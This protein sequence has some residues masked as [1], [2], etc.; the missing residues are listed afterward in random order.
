MDKKALM[1][2]VFLFFLKSLSSQKDLPFALVE[3]KGQWPEHV[4]FASDVQGG[5]V[6]FEK[7][8]LT[9]HLFDLSSII[10][11]HNE[12]KEFDQDDVRIKGH[13]YH[14]D[15]LG[16]NN[17][18]STIAEQRQQAYYNYFLGNDESG[19]AGGCNAFAS[20]NR[21]NFYNGIDLHFYTNGHVLKYDFIASP[22]ADVRQIKLKYRYADK[23]ELENGRLKITTSV[24]E[25][26]EQRPLAWQIIRGVKKMVECNYRL[27][28]DELSFS[29][30]K[31]YDLGY[32]LIIDPELVFSTYSGSFANN[33]GYTATYDL[34]GNLYGGGSVF[35]QGYPVT[36]G[37][38]QVTFNG[39]H[40]MLGGIDMGLTKYNTSGTALVWSTYLGGNGDDLP[41]SLVVNNQGEL[42]V[43]GTTGSNT[44]PVTSG[45]IDVSFN[46]GTTASSSGTG[47]NFLN[48]SDIVVT[49]FNQACT[50]LIASTYIGGTANDGL[51]LANALRYNY[52]DEFR[53]EIT[54]DAQGNP[55]IVS[56]TLSSDFPVFNAFQSSL[57]GQQD[58]VV[59]KLLPDMS[60]FVWSSYLGGSGNDSGF[61]A[62]E[63]SSGEVYICGGTNSTDFLQQSNVLQTSYGGGVADG[64]I[65]RLNSNGQSIASCTYWGSDTY[66]QVYFIEIDGNGM[67]YVFGQTRATDSQMIINASYNTPGSGNLL[68]K[69]S[70]DLSQV[71]WS[72]VFGPNT[73]R[74]TLSPSA[75]LVDYCNRVYISGWGITQVAGNALNPNQNLSS[76]ATM[77]V[78]PDAYDGTCNSGDFYMAVF[79]ENMNALEYATFFGGNQSSEHVDGG[80][81]RF[82]RKGVIYQSACAGCGGFDDFPAY[83]S[84]VWSAQNNNNCNNGVYKFDFQLPLTIADFEYTPVGCTNRPVHFQSTATYAEFYQWDFG[85]GQTSTATHPLHQYADVG[86][87]T[88]RLV[89]AS[90]TT[91]NGVDTLYKTIQIEQPVIDTLNDLHACYEEELQ[92]GVPSSNPNYQYS[93]SPT[94]YLNNPNIPNPTFEAGATTTYTVSVDRGGCVD[95]Y[96]Q[97]VEVTQ[98]SLQIPGDTTLCDDEE[99]VLA[100]MMQPSAA[101]I[102]W[103]DES[104][105]GN[106]LNDNST[107][108]D[109]VVT[110]SVPTTYYVQITMNGCVMTDEVFVNL[111]SFQTVIQGD[112]T[113]CYGDTVSLFVQDPNPTFTYSWQ[114]DEL[115]YIGQGTASVQVILVEPTLFTISSLTSDG[116]TANDSVQIS[117]SVLDR[118]EVSLTA[119]PTHI[120]EGQSSQLTAL[121]EGYNYQWSPSATLNSAV[122]YNPIASPTTTTTYNVTIRDGECVA[123]RLVT[124]YVSDF[125]CGRPTVYVPNSFTPNADSKNDLFYVRANQL[126]KLYFVIY[127]RWG[128]KVFETTSLETGWDGTF[129]G[130]PLDPDVYV[131]YLDI[132]C[133][134]GEEYQ[135]QGNITLIR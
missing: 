53:G 69:F 74:P 29:F 37:A 25:V 71:I 122:I 128:E 10:E 76:M 86:T 93:W 106:V 5:K 20:V 24:G 58:G 49:R 102:I 78:T 95:T 31:G 91:C 82:D 6:F 46:G 87:Y 21:K 8:Q 34:D 47:A 94:Q 117:V 121:P 9:Y 107:D 52:A 17:D 96:Y 84:N 85:D 100:A 54:L 16:A 67:V 132:T 18:A 120:V 4:L 48:G 88:I 72:T 61:S 133:V 114:P 14:V 119:E 30:P 33:F 15:F 42:F 109:I 65:V 13:V 28:N 134:G 104:S 98:L 92:L 26:Y 105:F 2:F 83:P 99:L 116:C 130:R 60:G 55:I 73:N 124:V 129:K 63:S 36:S 22:N 43:Y 45:V 125:I 27:E 75:F 97:T 38:Y 81:S 111:V 113:A 12:G 90:S 118:D 1:L 3:N 19:W 7:N 79:D 80:T 40:S 89:V 44:Y 103:S 56:S 23:L 41:H 50:A 64:F 77:P 70:A 135:E 123:T 35:G 101:N 126:S 110:P 127:D 57:A 131:Y 62:A 66:D 68:S 108:I 32:E 51:N 112:F 39:G 11:A 59:M 115:V